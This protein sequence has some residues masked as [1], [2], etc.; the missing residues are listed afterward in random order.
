M[1]GALTINDKRYETDVD[2][3]MVNGKAVRSSQ[4]PANDAQ[5][6]SFTTIEGLS[7]DA[8]HLC[9]RAW[10][11]EN[12]TQAIASATGTRVIVGASDDERARS[13]LAGRISS[14]SHHRPPRMK[15]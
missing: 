15:N 5:G 1:K 8:S 12:V 3:D 14:R 9:Q 6:R 11:E 13:V 7:R 4:I 2:D 10:L